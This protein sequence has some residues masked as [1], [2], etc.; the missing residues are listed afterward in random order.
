MKRTAVWLFAAVLL[1]GGCGK[2]REHR[3][4]ERARKDFVDPARKTAFD[5][6]REQYG[7]KF[8]FPLPYDRRFNN[9]TI[10][11]CK[12]VD[13]VKM[14]LGGPQYWAVEVEF[15][16]KDVVTNDMEKGIG[17]MIYAN[18]VVGEGQRDDFLVAVMAGTTEDDIGDIR[19][20]REELFKMFKR[21]L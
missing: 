16:G 12:I 2:S 17:V 18:V 11:E 4:V 1:V 14:P 3:V 9:C 20:L 7:L 6:M 15:E 10:S 13:Y 19:K 5:V 8:D 21:V